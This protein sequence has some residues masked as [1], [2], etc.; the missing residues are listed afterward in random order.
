MGLFLSACSMNVSLT[1]M[2]STLAPTPPTSTDGGGSSTI[3]AGEQV[4]TTVGTA[5]YIFN[6]VLYEIATQQTTASG[7]QIE[8]AFE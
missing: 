2:P 3:I 4:I 6:G 1:D 7:Y 8:G 5:G